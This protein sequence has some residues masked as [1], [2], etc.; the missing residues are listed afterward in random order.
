[1]TVP[2]RIKERRSVSLTLQHKHE[3][4]L[5]VKDAKFGSRMSTYLLQGGEETERFLGR[6]RRD[7]LFRGRGRGRGQG[8][9][10]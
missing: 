6:G 4:A 8:A 9:E 10:E 5:S 1:M 2:M 3:E 7:L